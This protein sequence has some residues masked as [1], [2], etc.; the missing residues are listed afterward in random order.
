MQST[1]PAN[2]C[3]ICKTKYNDNTTYISHIH[4][5]YKNEPYLLTDEEISEIN[6]K[7]PKI[8]KYRHSIYMKNINNHKCKI[9]NKTSST[10]EDAT[11]H[12]YFHITTHAS[13]FNEEQ[14]IEIT[15]VYNLRK[16]QKTKSRLKQKLDGNSTCHICSRVYSSPTYLKIHKH[17]HIETH[18]EEFTADEIADITFCYNKEETRLAKR[19]AAAMED[20]TILDVENDD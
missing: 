17:T 18:K 20:S 7:Y 6:K 15:R 8:K 16:E 4:G 13:E 12:M 10:Y 14:I 1:K 19:K 2:Y 3:N 5:H 11:S 9:C